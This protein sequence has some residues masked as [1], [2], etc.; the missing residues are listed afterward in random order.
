MM[1]AM[2]SCVDTV[3][4]IHKTDQS[5][6]AGSG[7]QEIV[8]ARKQ[9][10]GGNSGGCDGHV[11]VSARDLNSYSRTGYDATTISTTAAISK[12]RMSPG[13]RTN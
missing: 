4:R 6:G 1:E 9:R 12:A 5:A 3:G 8:R 2:G 7:F 13:T 10:Y 11:P